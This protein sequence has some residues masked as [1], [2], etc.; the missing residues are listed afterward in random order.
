MRLL[1]DLYRERNALIPHLHE[2]DILWEFVAISVRRIH[3]E[4]NMQ[5]TLLSNALKVKMGEHA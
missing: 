4:C 2:H 3:L 5:Q 1:P